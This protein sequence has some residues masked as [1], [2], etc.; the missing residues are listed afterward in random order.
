MVETVIPGDLVAVDM[1]R[2]HESDPDTSGGIG[3]NAT[4]E[5]E[6]RLIA[7]GSAERRG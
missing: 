3:R 5:E 6:A 4:P 2:Y 1:P 7:E